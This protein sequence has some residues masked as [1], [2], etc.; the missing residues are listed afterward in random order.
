MKVAIRSSLAFTLLLGAVTTA[1]V[2]PTP[3]STSAGGEL[4]MAV[5]GMPFEDALFRDGYARD[6]ERRHPELRVRYEKYSDVTQKYLAWHILGTGADVMRVRITDYDTLVARGILEPIDRFLDDLEL[7][8]DEDEQG[9]FMPWLWS[10]IELDGRR[11]ALPSDNA[12]Y[13]L[14]YN[15]AIFDQYRREHP[16]ETL[17]DPHDGWT[18]AELRDAA[19]RLT[20]RD[21]RGRI[22]QYGLDF[23]LWAW[24]FMSFFAQ[25]GGELWDNAGTTTRIDSP[26]GLEALQMIVDL[27]PHAGA[28]RSADVQDS[29][30]GPDKLFAAGRTAM[31]LDGS[32]RA[33]FLELVDPGLPF[34]IAPVPRHR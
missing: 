10:A 4:R 26:A 20:V 9:D 16:D 1:V 14:Y 21:G 17:E 6:F 5:W 23:D 11:Y 8:L 32:W 24:P 27:L 18:W 28:M 33:P 13:G 7:G 12:Q 19:A 25:A 22:V 2:V 34:A 15:R 3:E 31:L 30:T 29:A